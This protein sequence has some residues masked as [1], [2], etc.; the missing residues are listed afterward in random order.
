MGTKVTLTAQSGELAGKRFQ[1]EG[2]GKIIIGRGEDCDLQLPAGVEFLYASR[3]HCVIR[4]SF[5]QVRVRDLGSRNGTWLNGMQIGRPAAWHLSGLAAAMP[6]WEYDLHH[7]DELKVGETVFR[8]EIS[9]PTDKPNQKRVPVAS[10]Q[11]LC[12][13]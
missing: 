10:H 4:E 5:L 8:V 11:E 12:C 9:V 1:F 7:G 3:H 2:R 13:L 6:F